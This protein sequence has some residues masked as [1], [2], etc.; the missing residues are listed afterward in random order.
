VTPVFRC[1]SPQPTG[2]LLWEPMGWML[3]ARRSELAPLAAR[4]WPEQPQGS[5]FVQMR[6]RAVTG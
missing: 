1:L 6:T 4:E 2:P 5:A 3:Q